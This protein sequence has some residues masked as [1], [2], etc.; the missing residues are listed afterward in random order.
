MQY[1]EFKISCLEEY[2]EI[3]I[4]ELAEVGFDSFL[5]TDEGIDAYIAED[6]FDRE[7]YQ[8]VIDQYVEA[9]SILVKEG[10]MAKVNWN[11]E[12]EKHY[13][14]ISIGDEVYVRA[15]FHAPKIGVKHEIV[16][17]PKMSF[18]TGHHAT[19]YLMLS[20]Q[21]NVDHQGK[22]VIDIGSG[23]GILAIMAFKLGAEQIEAFDIDDWCVDNGNEN[24]ELNDMHSVK[25]GLGTIREV[26]PQGQFDIVLANINKNVLLDEM[27]V[28]GTLVKSKGKL[29]LSGFY[30][31]DI[32]DIENAAAKY[33]LDLQAKKTKDTWA[34]LIFEKR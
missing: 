1:L 10:M 25:M 17:N 13:D 30:E 19:T 6:L 21:L 4:S 29:L 16:I 9:A 14:P 18:G 3:L 27:E 5:E 34:S 32:V 12:W 7:A 22:R 23:T 15:S 20:H 2:R 11:E 33:G 31:H 8:A 26:N 24:F 28:Y